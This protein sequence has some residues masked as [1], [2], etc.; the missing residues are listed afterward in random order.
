MSVKRDVCLAGEW[1]KLY[2]SKGR[3]GGGGFERVTGDINR[4]TCTYEIIL[5]MVLVIVGDLR[6]TVCK[7]FEGINLV[8]GTLQRRADVSTVIKHRYFTKREQSLKH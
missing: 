4:K 3:G 5:D 8:K 1:R 6:A 2:K 7:G